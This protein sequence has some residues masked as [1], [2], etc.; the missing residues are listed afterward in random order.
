MQD[1][2]ICAFV[3]SCPQTD[4]RSAAKLDGPSEIGSSA[5][6]GSFKLHTY[7][8]KSYTGLSLLHAQQE[9]ARLWPTCIH[10][11]FAEKWQY[12]WM[13][14]FARKCN[15]AVAVLEQYK[16]AIHLPPPPSSQHL[17]NRTTQS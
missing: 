9:I 6:L 1:G 4:P 5:G 12:V 17:H 15:A 14:R 11:Y 10:D 16:K 2:L 8:S 7:R 3:L 13:A